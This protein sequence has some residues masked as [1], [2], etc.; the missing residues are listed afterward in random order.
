MGAVRTGK[1]GRGRQMRRRAQSTRS[2]FARGSPCP[3][4]LSSV[5]I[6]RRST[7]RGTSSVL[8]RGGRNI[9]VV[10]RPCK[11]RS[12]S[13]RNRDGA[14]GKESGC[15]SA[16]STNT[17]LSSFK[18]KRAV[19]SRYSKREVGQLEIKKSSSD[20]SHGAHSYTD[21]RT[22][23]SNESADGASRLRHGPRPHRRLTVS[24]ASSHL[25][26][27]YIPVMIKPRTRN[28]AAVRCLGGEG[29]LHGSSAQMLGPPPPP[30]S[31]RALYHPP[32]RLSVLPEAGGSDVNCTTELQ[33]LLFFNH[34]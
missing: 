7:S 28:N 10:S 19:N 2:H 4:L 11:A 29:Q 21:G 32:T 31:P 34:L 3:A 14:V 16:P 6:P 1:M 13:K 9:S 33:N 17:V 8:E 25:T 5:L 18:A 22:A 30:S 27:V 20:R 24:L 23:P 12:G 26:P 15:A